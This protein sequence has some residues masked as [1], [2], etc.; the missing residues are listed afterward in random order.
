MCGK[1]TFSQIQ[2]QISKYKIRKLK[3]QKYKSFAAIVSSCLGLCF[4]LVLPAGYV[5]ALLEL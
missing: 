5:A 1:G 3:I 4:V 2:S